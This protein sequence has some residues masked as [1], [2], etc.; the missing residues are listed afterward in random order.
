MYSIDWQKRGLPHAHIL[1]WLKSK[2]HS[3]QIDDIICP[4]NPDPAE[5]P[6]LFNIVTKS[7]MHGPCGALNSLSSC[8]VDNKCTKKYP[9]EFVHETRTGDDAYPRCR[10]RKPEDEGHTVTIR[11][12]MVRSKSTTDGLY[13]TRLCYRRH[14]NLISTWNTE[15]L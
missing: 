11:A 6:L 13:H 3:I 4:E 9:R 14:S 5:D 10:R 1:I 8:M 7:M 15:I 2:I 12:R